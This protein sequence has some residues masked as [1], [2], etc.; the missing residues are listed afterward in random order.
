MIAEMLSIAERFDI[1]PIVE[2]FGFA[3]IDRALERVRSN[4]V[5]YRAVLMME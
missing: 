4:T 5:R 3:D 1:Q 2:V